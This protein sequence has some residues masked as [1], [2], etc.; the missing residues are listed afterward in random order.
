MNLK[1][2]LGLICGGTIGA[3]SIGSACAW[4]A[5]DTDRGPLDCITRIEHT[6][7]AQFALERPVPDCGRKVPVEFLFGYTFAT[8]KSNPSVATR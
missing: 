5:S 4:F 8:S 2:V 6:S 7:A 3:L 1:G